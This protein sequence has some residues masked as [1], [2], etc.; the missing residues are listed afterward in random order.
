VDLHS[1]I[2]YPVD[3][4]EEVTDG[5]C[6]VTSTVFGEHIFAMDIS[7]MDIEGGHEG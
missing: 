1:G 7:A 3:I 2:D 6:I 5:H 4:C